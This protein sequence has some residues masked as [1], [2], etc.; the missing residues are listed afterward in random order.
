MCAKGI[1]LW[2]SYKLRLA[3]QWTSGR[4]ILS[5]RPQARPGLLVHVRPSCDSDCPPSP[6]LHPHWSCLCPPEVQPKEAGE[7][8][9]EWRKK[10]QEQWENEDEGPDQPH[11]QPAV[12]PSPL[13]TGSSL[14][15]S[16]TKGSP[17]HHPP[18]RRGGPAPPP[19]TT[20][21]II[22]S[23]YA[24]KRVLCHIRIISTPSM[25]SNIQLR[26]QKQCFGQALT[27]STFHSWPVDFKSNNILVC[28]S[29]PPPLPGAKKTQLSS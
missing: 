13:L 2:R 4:G 29:F 22:H 1:V 6:P 17:T 18:G 27:G 19:T 24:L 20:T 14:R 8:D 25:I 7:G 26:L 5:W 23:Y 28:W 16:T 15:H 3:V 10:E 11:Q 12:L 21:P 9:R